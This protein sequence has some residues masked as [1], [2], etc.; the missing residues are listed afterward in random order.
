MYLS[1]LSLTNFRLFRHLELELPQGVVVMV[2]DNAQGK[3]TI[4]EAIYALAIAKSF[5]ADNESEVVSWNAEGE[6]T[7]IAGTLETRDEKLSIRVGYQRP[8]AEPGSPGPGR[9]TTVKKEIR[10]SRVRRTSAQ[11]VGVVN[12]ALFN[13]EDIGLVQGPPALRRRYLDVLVSQV[14]PS[15]LRSLQRYQRVLV[16]RNRLL[17]LLQVGAAG[18]DELPYWDGELIKEGSFVL[19][20]RRQVMGA[21]AELC[22]ENHGDLTGGRERIHLEYCPSIGGSDGASPE[23]DN[24]SEALE[25]SRSRELAVGS[26]LVGPHRDDFRI[27]VDGV[28]MGT[29]AS[30]GQARTLALTLRLSEAAFLAFSRGEGPIVLLD[31]VLSEMDSFRRSRVLEKSMEYQ[32]VIVTTT[33]LGPLRRGPL[34][35]AACY[36]VAGGEVI[37]LPPGTLQLEEGGLLVP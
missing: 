23:E 16:Q 12:A 5:R 8:S 4:L 32:Q 7:L 21:L 1:H 24:F 35:D 11:L 17:R 34:S 30:R 26:T 22:R 33:D 19:G 36:R 28:D 15:Y 37:P 20:R 6:G 2:G 18:R 13:A 10:V 3:S 9:R 27:T 29:Y 25:A 14:D 31:D